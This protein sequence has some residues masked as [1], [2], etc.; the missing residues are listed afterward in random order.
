M[1]QAPGVVWGTGHRTDK[2]ALRMFSDAYKQ[3][4]GWSAASWGYGQ[5]VWRG[6]SQ[7]PHAALLR[8]LRQTQAA[9]GGKPISDPVPITGVPVLSV[10]TCWE[11][12]HGLKLTPARRSFQSSFCWLLCVGLSHAEDTPMVL[13][14]D[15]EHILTFSIS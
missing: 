14:L 8:V 2:P 15:Q 1:R 9:W 3:G 5:D 7:C 4:R 13:W 10:P 12:A 6:V 11:G